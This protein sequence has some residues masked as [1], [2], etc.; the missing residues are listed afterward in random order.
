MSDNERKRLKV[1]ARL[2]SSFVPAKLFCV[3]SEGGI[4]LPDEN[5]SLL[6]CQQKKQNMSQRTCEVLAERR[7]TKSKSP[8]GAP[9][10]LGGVTGPSS[11]SP[12]HPGPIHTGESWN[13][14]NKRI[15]RCPKSLAYPYRSDLGM[16]VVVNLSCAMRHESQTFFHVQTNDTDLCLGSFVLRAASCVMRR[17]SESIQSP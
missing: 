1:F 16:N 11:V 7:N 3:N 14:W 13:S 15:M 6:P 10:R 12:H 2:S 17:V 8:A 5:C 9:A 4:R